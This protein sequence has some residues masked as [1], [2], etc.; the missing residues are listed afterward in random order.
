MK[1]IKNYLLLLTALIGILSLGLI[2]LPFSYKENGSVIYSFQLMFGMNGIQMSYF[3]LIG[4]I[5]PLLSSAALFLKKVYKDYLSLSCLGFLL[6]GFFFIIV[7]S[8]TSYATDYKVNINLSGYAI[9]YI[10]LAFFAALILFLLAQNE[11]R[12]SVYDIVETGMLVALAVG[13]DLPELKIQIGENGGSISFTMVPLFIL[14][15]RQGPVKGMIGCG[16]VYGFITCILDGWG[17][18]YFPFDYLLGYGAV[19]IIGLFKSLIFNGDNTR[20]TFTGT[21]F[22]IIGVICSAL[23]RLCAAT[24]SGMIFYELD[25]IGSLS[26]NCLYILPSAGVCL[27]IIIVLYKPLMIIDKRLSSR[28]N[29]SSDVVK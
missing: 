13:L 28:Q 20:F 14:A 29:I 25:F 23:G 24:I 21:L 2:F 17:L 8:F 26:Y 9:A 1:K 12:F 27:A 6:T 7:P 3:V 11:N 22:L 19:A 10:S 18:V 5:L 4:F 16:I 15:L